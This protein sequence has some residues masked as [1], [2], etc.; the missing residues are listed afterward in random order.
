MPTMAAERSGRAASDARTAHAINRRLGPSSS[1]NLTD[2]SRPWENRHAAQSAR[3]RTVSGGSQ[4]ASN[5]A[6][7]SQH[8]TFWIA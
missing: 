4:R 6:S 5:H 2:Q 1:A 8:T 7:S 3:P